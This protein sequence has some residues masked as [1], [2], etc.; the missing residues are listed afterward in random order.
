MAILGAIKSA[1]LRCD[2]SVV[3][4]VFSSTDQICVEM[5]D[6]CNDVAE[7]IAKGHDW[8]SLTK[9]ATISGAET[10][11]LP[12]DYDR[13]TAGGE[14]DDPSTW[15]WG[16][17]P[18]D[19]VNQW[20][21]YRN[22]QYIPVSPGGWI[23]MGGALN[24]YPAPTG[25][26]VFPYVSNRFVRNGSEMKTEFSTDQDE[27]VL[28]ERLMTL[29]LIWRWKQMKGLEY[30][31]DMQT[32]SNAL[33]VEQGRDKGAYVLRAPRRGRLCGPLAYSGRAVK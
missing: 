31:E 23:I 26:A 18:F 25:Q 17:E 16:Y 27:F 5:A 1:V 10:V 4:E 19:S 12:S 29:G 20:M 32:Y 8:R 3:E 13:M 9:V 33:E 2:G 24:F 28:P 30:A 14:I 11:A 7:E 21:R 22:G 15:F 6:L